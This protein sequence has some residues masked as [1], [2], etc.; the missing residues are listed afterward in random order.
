MSTPAPG[1]LS[2]RSHRRCARIRYRPSGATAGARAAAADDAAPAAKRRKSGLMAGLAHAQQAQRPDGEPA[3]DSA[4]SAIDQ[5][6]A[7]EIDSFTAIND[8]VVAQVMI[9]PNHSF[10]GQFNSSTDSYF[11]NCGRARTPSTTRTT[12]SSTCTSSGSNTSSRC[13]CTTRSTSP[14]WAARRWRPPTW[15]PSSQALA[16]SRWRRRLRVRCTCGRSS[17]CTTT[18]STRACS[19]PRRRSSRAT[20]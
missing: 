4:T 12:T 14:R 3:S 1:V 11:R 8:K 16:N 2:R 20:C 9:K 7:R 19:P 6:V 18:G 15:S 10:T 13:R 5:M 17:R